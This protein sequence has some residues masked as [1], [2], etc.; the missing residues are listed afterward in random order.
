MHDVFPKFIVEGNELIIGNC[1][2]HKQL[3][4]DPLKVKG[5]GWWKLDR[6]RKEFLLYGESD[7]FGKPSIDVI[8]SCIAAGNV[9]L[10]YSGGKNVSDHTFYLKAGIETIK[11]N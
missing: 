7:D 9:F 8:K 6:E 2:Y 10:S 11:L 5:G 1:T 4:S 3:A